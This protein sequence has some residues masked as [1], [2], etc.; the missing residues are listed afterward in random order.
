MHMHPSKMLCETATN[1]PVTIHRGCALEFAALL[2]SPRFVKREQQMR[3]PLRHRAC[4][5]KYRMPLS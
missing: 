3:F 1:F 5:A 2:A 4:A